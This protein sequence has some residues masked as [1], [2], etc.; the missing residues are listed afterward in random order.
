M[1]RSV[2]VQYA[3]F[4]AKPVVREY[5]FLVR[6]V[7]SEPR[8]FTFTIPNQAFQ[9]DRVRDQDAP[10]ICSIK[11]HRELADWLNHP[12]KTHYRITELELNDYRDSH[13]YMKRVHSRKT[14]RD[15]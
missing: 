7:S 13:F 15:L 14:A 6:D 11:L 5:C 2:V 12:L 4:T 9:S 8:E 3:G 1:S 10:N